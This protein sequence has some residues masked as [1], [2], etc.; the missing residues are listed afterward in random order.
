MGRVLQVGIDLTSPIALHATGPDIPIPPNVAD[1]LGVFIA[2][3]DQQDVK[4]GNGTAEIAENMKLRLPFIG[5]VN[6]KG[7]FFIHIK[8]VG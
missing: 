8:Q 1:A 3:Y 4:P 2:W 5:T 7:D 6:E